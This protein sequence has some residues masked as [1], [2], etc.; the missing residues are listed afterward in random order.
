MLRQSVRKIIAGTVGVLSCVLLINSQASASELYRV[1]ISA[2][3][4]AL[5]GE[6]IEISVVADATS[7]PDLSLAVPQLEGP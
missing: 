6:L 2:P 3:S 5:P 1:S 7:F 4:S